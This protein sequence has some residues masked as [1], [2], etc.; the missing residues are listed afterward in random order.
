M[1]KH[2]HTGT[3]YKI[4]VNFKISSSENA[5]IPL[6]LSKC[7]FQICH[8]FGRFCFLFHSFHLLCDLEHCTRKEQLFLLLG[9]CLLVH[10]NLFHKQMIPETEIHKISVNN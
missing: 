2:M 8:Q 1:V 9:L 7:L 3:Q 4:K 6:M 5:S 10:Q